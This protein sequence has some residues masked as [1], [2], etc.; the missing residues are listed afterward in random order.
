MALCL[1]WSVVPTEATAITVKKQAI[2]PNASLTY[3]SRAFGDQ[4][5]ES[6]GVGN[7]GKN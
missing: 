2:L 5:G 3:V 1:R 4:W 6:G 7:D